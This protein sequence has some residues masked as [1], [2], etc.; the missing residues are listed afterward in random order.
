MMR[1]PPAGIERTPPELLIQAVDFPGFCSPRASS[2]KPGR[3]VDYLFV[4]NVLFDVIIMELLLDPLRGQKDPARY[5][6]D[7]SSRH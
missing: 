6:K 3:Q 5:P 2:I 1:I 4:Y 7:M